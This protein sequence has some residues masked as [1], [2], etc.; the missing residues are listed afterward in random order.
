MQILKSA[1]LGGLF[2]V[3]AA[4]SAAAV[5]FNGNYSLSGNA[6]S[7][8]GLVIQTSATT[9]AF[10]FNLNSGQSTTFDLFSIWT[11]ENRV[12]GN[13]TRVRTLLA[14]FMLSSFGASGTASGTTTGVNVAGIAQYGSLSWAAPLT[15][16]LN[17]GGT[18]T[19]A[20]SNETFNLGL[21]RLS[22]G[23]NWAA[24]VQAT[25][26]YRAPSAVPLPASGLLLA[27][28]VATA[29]GMRRRRR[30]A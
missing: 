25:A 1:A 23:I 7:E 16:T 12:N 22:S 9:G 5:T 4:I 20:L 28:A 13:N 11:N 19:I 14:D 6:Y 3:S 21:L 24:T 17:N 26:T 30:A 8:P 29:A 18:L 15:L 27:A 10:S 2:V